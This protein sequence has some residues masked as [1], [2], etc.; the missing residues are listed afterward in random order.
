MSELRPEA[1]RAGAQAGQRTGEDEITRLRASRDA[2]VRA[3]QEAIYNTTRL[4]RLL[5]VLGDP[6]SLETL[7]DRVLATLSEL[8]SADIVILVDPV[9]TG[10]FAPLAAI[11][12][13][14]E[15]IQR[16]ILVGAGSYGMQAMETQQPV[17][18]E[19]A[20][21]N[22]GVDPQLHELDAETVVYLPVMDNY[23]ARGVLVLARCRPS[24]FTYA[25]AELLT[26]MAYRIGLSLEQAQ[27]SSQLG[28]FVEIVHEIGRFLDEPSVCAEAVKRFPEI[29]KGDAAALVLTRLDRQPEC[30]AQ[31]GFDPLTA[32]VWENI[33]GAL[34]K[35]D[36]FAG[37]TPFN[38]ADLTKDNLLAEE[39]PPRCPARAVL[40]IPIYREER[41]EGVLYAARFSSIAFNPVTLQVAVLFAGQ[42]LAALENARM[43]RAARD[44]LNERKRAEKALRASENRSRA[45]IAS[46]S[47]VIAILDSGG[48]VSYASPAIGPLWGC[49]ISDLLGCSIFDRVSPY[50]VEA[51]R[52]LLSDLLER[53]GGTL[54]STARLLQ[55]Q[56]TW[57]DYEVIFTNLLDEPAVAG[58]VATFHDITERKVYEGK[59]TTMAYRDPLTGLANRA[60]FIDQLRHALA[61][62]ATNARSVAVI[63]FDLDN[64]KIVNDSLG[65]DCGDDVLREVAERVKACMRQGD[66]VAR[67]GGDEF[68]ILL[69]NVAGVERVISIV[70]RMIDTVHEPIL[71][72]GHDLFV[73]CSVG[74]AVSVQGYEDAEEMLRRADLAMYKAKGNGKGRYEV[75]DAQLNEKAIARLELESELRR[76]LKHEELRVYYQ[77]I[78]SLDEKKVVEL[79]ALV[80]W[81]HPQRGLVLPAGILPIAEDSGLIVELD[82]WVLKEACRQARQWQPSYP[83]QPPLSVSVNLSERMFWNSG[84][85][86]DIRAA[87]EESGLDPSSLVLEIT[88]SSMINS[89][90]VVFAKLQDIK[91]IGVKLAIDD[92]GTGYASLSYLKQFPID[93]IKIDRSFVQGIVRDEKDEA[94]VQS[95]LYLAAAFGMCSVGEGIETEEQVTALQTLMCNRGQGY[96]FAPP[97]PAEEVG[98]YLAC[99]ADSR[100]DK[101]SLRM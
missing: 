4:T 18:V 85:V 42:T 63:F 3:A 7:L 14:E 17:L 99:H 20:L 77:P 40:A 100:G 75:Y 51:V 97:M 1:P 101:I 39:L 66:T 78:F 62:A 32:F 28:Q 48:T 86:N 90:E 69:E 10:S 22:P 65:H 37:N 68:T 91:S 9:G 26:A 5:A 88:E 53:P 64:F 19:N 60:Y 12:L 83:S 58:I 50:D 61:R 94:I 34:L 46:V 44:E 8:F 2:A 29:V 33:T 82:Q 49:T 76:A 23:A 16:Q 11:G 95:M 96:L 87:L 84:L 27:R 21:N 52:A 73:G 56:D 30:A 25:D 57:R 35:N 80:R 43:Y 55:G 38:T 70:K 54:T 79:E 71:L 72:K 41:I 31:Q 45:L 92:F 67:F 89:P 36:V 24:S 15:I 6:A 13:P 74:I 47:D 98:R 81:Q 93:T 59:L